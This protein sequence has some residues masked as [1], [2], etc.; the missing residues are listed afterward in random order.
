MPVATAAMRM[1]HLVDPRAELLAE[2]AP[3]VATK[4]IGGHD[5]LL[6]GYQRPHRTASGI[7]ITEKT[8]DEDKFQGKVGLIVAL[9]PLVW[10]DKSAGWYGDNPPQIGDWVVVDVN[11]TTAV[12]IGK[13]TYRLV[14]DSYIRMVIDHPDEIL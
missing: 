4:R 6:A 13:R 9:G 10:Q 11:T 8:R 12:V 5:I 7:F 14:Q 1:E 3:V 2:V